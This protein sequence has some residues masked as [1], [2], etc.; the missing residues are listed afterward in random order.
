MATKKEKREAALAKREAFLKEERERGLAAQKRDRE[1]Q[2]EKSRAAAAEANK[3]NARHR[4]IL[5]N[6]FEES[7]RRVLERL[8]KDIE[9]R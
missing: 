4:Q 1:E 9:V 3:I 5:D 7:H 2:A 6:F 8:I